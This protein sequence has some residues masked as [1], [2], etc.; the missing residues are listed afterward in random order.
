M[1]LLEDDGSELTE[2]CIFGFSEWLVVEFFRGIGS[3][4]RLFPNNDRNQQILFGESKL[5]VKQIRCLD[6]DKHD[7]MYLWQP[8]CRNW[9][10]KKG[11]YPNLGTESSRN[12][13]QD[14]LL[15]R[16]RKLQQWQTEIAKLEQE[17]KA[18]CNKIGF[19]ISCQN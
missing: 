13:T 11:I 17:A 16:K 4:M 6:G 2:V 12:P 14:K 9:L 1:D 15:E 3:E 7:H 19:F 5:T 8:N 10:E 18:Y